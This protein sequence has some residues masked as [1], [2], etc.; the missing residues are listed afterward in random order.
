MSAY[1]D[2]VLALT[3]AA[4]WR[5]GD[6]TGDLVDL[7]GNVLDMTSQGTPTYGQPGAVLGD[8]NKSIRLDGVDA[9]YFS[10]AGSAFLDVDDTFSIVAW[11]KKA[12]DGR[13]QSILCSETGILF[14]INASNQLTV[15]EA[16]VAYIATSVTTITADG[17]W[18]F[19]GVAKNGATSITLYVD[20]VASTTLILDQTIVV[21]STSD[22]NIGR[23]VGFNTQNWNG[24]LGEIAL[25]PAVLSAA[26][27]ADLR[28]LGIIAGG[29]DRRRRR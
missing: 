29:D 15:G 9:N 11:V 27:F 7:A 14:Q 13:I 17:K 24:W 21:A 16:G 5:C 8:P 28:E 4:Y 23:N 19:V 10:H 12:E 1:S 20:G 25:F 3:P 6:A 26:N 22:W 2:A 18:H